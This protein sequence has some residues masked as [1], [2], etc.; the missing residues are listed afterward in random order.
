[1]TRIEDSIRLALEVHKGQVDKGGHPYILH[2]LH[3]METVI[4]QL[5]QLQLSQSD[6][7]VVTCTAVLHD[8]VEDAVIPGRDKESAQSYLLTYIGEFAGLY[9]SNAVEALTRR[10]G[11]SWKRYLNRVAGIRIARIVKIADLEHNM[12][13]SRLSRVTEKDKERVARYKGALDRLTNA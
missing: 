9:V 10:E 2:S 12:D 6:C 3:V 8:T 1:M 4:C 13:L 7:E 11:D 5:P